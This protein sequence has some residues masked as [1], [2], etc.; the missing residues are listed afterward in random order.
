MQQAAGEWQGVKQHRP[1]KPHAPKAAA[2]PSLQARMPSMRPFAGAAALMLPRAHRNSSSPPFPGQGA[3]RPACWH[4]GR[5]C[6]ACASP[7]GLCHVSHPR[8]VCT[9]TAASTL[10][11]ALPCCCVARV[12]LLQGRFLARLTAASTMRQQT[13]P[14]SHG[15]LLRPR[16]PVQRA[17]SHH[18]PRHAPYVMHL[19]QWRQPVLPAAVAAAAAAKAQAPVI[20]PP[21]LPRWCSRRLVGAADPARGRGPALPAPRATTCS[22]CRCRAG[23]V[24]DASAWAGISPAGRRLYDRAEALRAVHAWLP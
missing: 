17:G 14:W 8:C 20:C 23:S 19:P 13:Q 9:G 3:P 2:K 10:H 5:C 6:A 12:L 4:H 16:K 24:R 11:T 18:L 15:M 21:P 7:G 22:C 1:H